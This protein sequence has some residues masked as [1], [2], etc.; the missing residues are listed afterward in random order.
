[1]NIQSLKLFLQETL[2]TGLILSVTVYASLRLIFFEVP[3]S[4]SE[5]GLI[6]LK[7]I[8]CG[9][10]IVILLRTAW[11]LILFIGQKIK[12]TASKKMELSTDDLKDSKEQPIFKSSV[13]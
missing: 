3:F 2:L 8:L 9:W 7:T 13:A 12:T 4:F 10:I 11:S 1:M 6:L 5:D